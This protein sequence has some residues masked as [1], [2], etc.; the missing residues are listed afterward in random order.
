M[1]SGEHKQEMIEQNTMSNMPSQLRIIDVWDSNFFEEYEKIVE[2]SK[3]YPY[4]AMDTEFPGIVE[5][6]R[7]RTSDYE[8]QL[9]K[10]NVD[11]LKLIQLGITLFDKNGKTP[12]GP[13][14]WQFNFKYDVDVD[15]SLKQSIN[16]LR[17]AGINFEK[18]KT[19]GID[20]HTFSYYLTSSGLVLDSN[21]TW[22]CFQGNQDFGY[23]YRVLSN[24]PVP[25]SE[26]AFLDE[27]KI[28]FPNLFD[29]KYM[30]HEFDELRGGLQRLGDALH[31][32]RVGQMHQAGSDSWLTGLAFF[33]LLNTYHKDKD[34]EDYRN[35]IFGFG[36]SEND[37]YYLES[38]HSKTDQL[39]RELRERD[40]RDHRDYQ[41]EDHYQ[42]HEHYNAYNHFNGGTM[43]FSK[44][45]QDQ[46]DYAYNGQMAPEYSQDYNHQDMATGYMNTA[47]PQNNLMPSHSPMAPTMGYPPQSIS[48]NMHAGPYQ[49]N[50]GM[51]YQMEDGQFAQGYPQIN[52]HAMSPNPM[53]EYQDPNGYNL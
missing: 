1:N 46:S 25:D 18:H 27:T 24:R 21:K 31:L 45:Q 38:Y 2:L 19:N 53:P 7:S 32:D 20:H 51:E 16:V 26:D 13:C 41:P 11:E 42:N 37:E 36:I 49:M 30:K 17:E 48:P 52:R 14:T 6:P 28:Y 29:I 5:V 23:M 33:K 35:V 10:I 4:I 8:Y 3:D 12:P 39:E 15:K 22:I 50:P 34:L 47:Y 44:T 9:V 40:F 43:A